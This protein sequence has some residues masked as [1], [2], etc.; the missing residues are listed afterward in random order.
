MKKAPLFQ[1][2]SF[3]R[4]KP[5]I[6]KSKTYPFERQNELSGFRLLY[7]RKRII[8][9]TTTTSL[10]HNYDFAYGQLQLFIYGNQKQE[11]C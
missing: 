9:Q 2:Q 1:T 7:W 3:C 4:P 8:I 6:L 5:I 11:A 10:T